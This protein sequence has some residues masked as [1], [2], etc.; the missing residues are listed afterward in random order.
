MNLVILVDLKKAFDTVDY[1][2]LSKK[3][4]IGGIRG[5]TLSLLRSYLANRTKKMSKK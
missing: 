1:E 5:S 2:I 3:F 4:E